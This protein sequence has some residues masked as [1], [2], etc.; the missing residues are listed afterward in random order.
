GE[1]RT[2]RASAIRRDDVRRFSRCGDHPWLADVPVPV[3]GNVF[4][5]NIPKSSN[6]TSPS[7]R[8]GAPARFLWLPV[9]AYMAL[10]F[11]LSSL[12]RTPA[13]VSHVDKY[14]HAMLY[15]GFGA[16]LVRAFAGGWHRRVT[17]SV[18][19]A[20]ILIAALYGV[21]DEFHQSFVPHRNVEAMDVVADTMGASIAAVAL[22]AWDIIRA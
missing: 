9:F 20:T 5:P 12:S 16:L 8:S 22:F 2:R 17:V 21:S 14:L 10:I 19:V 7:N 4:L 3:L 18:V 13:F 11:A 1:R 6:S 15:A